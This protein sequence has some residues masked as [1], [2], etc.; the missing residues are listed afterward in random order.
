MAGLGRHHKVKV[1]EIP[2]GH[3]NGAFFATSE[4][5]MQRLLVL[6]RWH[7]QEGLVDLLSPCLEDD[8]ATYRGGNL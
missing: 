4:A 5:H 3:G 1:F 7:F 2:H 6:C 8:S